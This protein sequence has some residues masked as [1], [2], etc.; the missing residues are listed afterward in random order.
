[1]SER[2]R[3]D[4]DRLA[5]DLPLD[6][7]VHTDFSHDADVPLH[8]YAA[9]ARERAIAEIA[10]TDHLDFDA[11]DP[12]FKLGE[13]SRR[14]R[15]AREVAERWEGRPH[16]R[17]GAEITYERRLEPE[18]RA[19][20][21]T[22]PYDY[23][24]GSVHVSQ[25]TPLRDAAT[26]A[27]WCAGRSFAEVSGWYWEEVLGAIRSG[28]FDTLGHLDVVKRWLFPHTGPLEYAGNE[29][30]YEPALLALVESEV[31]LEVNSSGLRQEPGAM[32]PSAPVVE[33]YRALGGTRVTAG[34]DAH[35]LDSFGFALADAYHAIESAGLAELSFRRGP[36]HGVRVPLPGR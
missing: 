30:L 6:S 16:I 25:R 32:Y 2:P 7:H 35:R 28:L 9:A 18:I 14:E 20:L 33:R 31:A 17:F 10:V 11:G 34:S 3:D 15:V 1:M 4:D 12:N 22:H 21:S 23:V 5:R 27:R 19:Y 36:G 24:I 13:H 29:E 8:L 26:A